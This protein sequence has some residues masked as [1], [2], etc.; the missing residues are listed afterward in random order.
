MVR[1]ARMT[2][3]EAYGLFCEIRWQ[4]TGGDPVCP[5]CGHEKA[6]SI[7]TRRKFK[8][9][10]CHHQ[11]SVTRRTIFA[12]RKLA[13]RDILVA[14]AIFVNGAKGVPALRLSRELGVQYK[15]AFVLA[16]KIREAMADHQS[17]IDELSGEVEVDGAYF[18]GHV[19]PKNRKLDRKDRRTRANQSAKRCAVA[20][21]RERNGRT[22]VSVQK[23]EADAVKTLIDRIRP[24]TIVFA[25]EASC[26]DD[27]HVYFDTRRI[28]HS[29]S[30]SEDGASTNWAESFFSRLRR[31]E[32]GIHHHISGKYLGAY[33]GE[34]AWRE[35]QRR[36]G[37]RSQTL[38]ALGLG[39]GHGVSRRWKG[40]WQRKC[41]PLGA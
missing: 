36:S 34:M 31:S 24:E 8:C 12:S 30:Y 6:Y 28:N 29:E 11:F 23:R 27:F 5:R 9:K 15:T 25:D 20:V 2:E 17:E 26:W 22:F 14:I 16:H 35:D 1:V 40:Y 37:N 38:G 10:R 18:G 21:G 4:E 41:Q 3:E 13:F 33:A 7:T 32:I 39:L 19:R